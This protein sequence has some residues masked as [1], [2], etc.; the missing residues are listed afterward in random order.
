MLQI[1]Q[2][3]LLKIDN[4]STQK[5]VKHVQSNNKNTRTASMTSVS[6][7]DFKQ[8]NVSWVSV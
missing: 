4:R 8:V 7:A 6:I 1:N 2:H 3:Y 5:G